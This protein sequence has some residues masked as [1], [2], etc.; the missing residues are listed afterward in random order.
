M[1]D[2]LLD[3]LVWLP[4]FVIGGYVLFPLLT[5]FMQ[6]LPA[7]PDFEPL[8]LKALPRTTAE[9]L[10]THTR[11][12]IAL[13]FED[14]VMAKLPNAAPDVTGYL[15]LLANR[16]AGDMAMV[17]VLVGDNGLVRQ[18]AFLVEFST[19]SADGLSFDTIN[20]DQ[21]NA[22]P[23]GPGT[24]R[25]QAWAA[26]DVAELYRLHRHVMAAHGFDGPREVYPSDDP[27]EWLAEHG[28]ERMYEVHAAR[29]WLARTRDGE[30]FVP[31]L[32]GA[33]LITWGLMP[34]VSWVRKLLIGQRAARLLAELRR[35]DAAE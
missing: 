8:D 29:G 34:P 20:T 26:V 22:F 25:T 12:L 24:T 15:I 1:S 19:G 30:A 17:T 31:T 23:P 6:R 13:G 7:R 33:Y 28:F 35:S 14:P 27:L 5:Y 9:Y 18:K 10:M 32:L 4:A 11:E 2:L 3:T 21:L 16:S